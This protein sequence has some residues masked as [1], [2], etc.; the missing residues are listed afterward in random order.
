MKAL[1]QKIRVVPLK[2]SI[3]YVFICTPLCIVFDKIIA[4]AQFV[5]IDPG[6]FISYKR[7]R[8]EQGILR[9]DVP[10]TS[11]SLWRM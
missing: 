8:T 11:Y 1:Q 5:E 9:K 7:Q 3:M 4:S 10:S 6:L 2:N